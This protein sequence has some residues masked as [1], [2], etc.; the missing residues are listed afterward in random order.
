VQQ[1]GLLRGAQ[2]FAA[3]L[4]RGF[5]LADGVEILKALEEGLSEGHGIAPRMRDTIVRQGGWPCR[6]GGGGIKKGAEGGLGKAGGLIA[7]LSVAPAPSDTVGLLVSEGR[8]AR[9]AD[10]GAQAGDGDSD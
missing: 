9:G 1:R 2:A 4:H 8:V 6:G 10:A 3:G 7:S 5:G